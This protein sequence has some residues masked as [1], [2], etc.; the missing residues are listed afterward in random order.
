MASIEPLL[1]TKFFIPQLREGYIPRPRLN[2]CL[3]RGLNGSVT[4]VSAPAG[5][6]KTTLVSAWVAIIDNPVVWLSLDE[7]DNEITRFLTYLVNSIQQI[8]PKIGVDVLAA[9]DSTQSPQAEILLTLMINGVA[10]NASQFI[11]ILDDCHLISNNEVFEALEFLISHK[12]DEMHVMF[13]GRVDPQISLSRLRAGGQLT[14]IRSRDLRFSRMETTAFLNDYMDLDLSIEDITTLEERTE[15]WI[16]GLQ[17]VGLSLQQRDDRH[18]FIQSF[19]GGHRHLI[20]YLGEEVL[21]HQ[22]EEIRSFL[23]RS[24]IL[25]R[26]NPSLCDATL[27]IANSSQILYKIEGMNLFLIPLDDER[28]WFRYHHLFADFLKLCLQNDEPNLISELHRRAAGWYKANWYDREV[29]GHLLS[30]GEFEEATRFVEQKALRLLEK[31][32]LAQLMNWIAVLP[33]ENVLQHPRLSIYQIWALRLSGGQYDVVENKINMIDAKLEEISGDYSI[34]EHGSIYSDL[35]DEL[36]NLKTHIYGLRAFQGIYSENLTEAKEMVEKGRALSPDEKFVSSGLGFAMGWA[37]RLSGNLSAAFDEFYN[38]SR[39]SKESGNI[40]MA[41]STLCRA[42]YGLVLGAKLRKAEQVFAEALDIAHLESGKRYPV[43]GYAYVYLGGI[44]YEWNE[45]ETAKRY[46]LDGIQ[47]CERVGYIMDQAVGYCYLARINL[48]E[49]DIDSAQDACQSAIEL[50]QL[51]KDYLYL[52]RWVDDCQVRLWTAQGDFGS[53]EKWVQRSGMRIEDALDFKR[54]ID[55]I[56]LARAL[57]VL[58]KCRP[59]SSYLEDILTL[60]SKLEV[61]AED[62]KWYGKLIEILVLQAMALQ[63]SKNEEQA[64]LSLEK[65]ISLAQP[66]GYMRSFVDEG[67][68]MGLLLKSLLLNDEDNSFA[69]NLLATYDLSQSPDLF[70][71]DQAMLEPL[72]S[73]ELEVMSMLASDLSGPEIADE[74]YIALST[75]RFHTRNIYGKLQVNNRRAAVGKARDLNLI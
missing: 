71:S 52:R 5:Y 13:I 54:D 46:V 69:R 21:S 53:L 61:M 36:R 67:L 60:L 40:F 18:E 51:M 42:A 44:Y 31:S 35:D 43:A 75:L 56:I 41:V 10:A 2:E 33:E 72:S 45:L 30:A 49:G 16:A 37:N 19:S 38:S 57:L 26:L 47:L 32:E 64:I 34:L 4:I 63:I 29:L 6:G 59:S 9:L 8:N 7:Q 1:T 22:P 17:L 66:E 55:H 50:S 20:D 48:A 23:C 65:A 15:G 58:S 68:P 74:M 28:R 73:R 14:E 25:D 3:D 62:A 39:I 24:S 11:L 12:P 70:S 27:N